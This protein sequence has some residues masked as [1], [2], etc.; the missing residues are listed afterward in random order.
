MSTLEHT[1]SVAFGKIPL[2]RRISELMQDRGDAFSIRA[3]AERL[4]ENRETFRQTL[5]G[6]RPISITLLENIAKGLK[7]DED[8][9]RQRDTFKKE[10]ELNSLLNAPERTKAMMLRAETL[11]K[12]LVDVAIG[13]TEP[14]MYWAHLG[15]AQFQLQLYDHAHESWVTSMRYAEKISDIFKDNTL[16]YHISSFLLISFT[17]RREYTN[18]LHTLE[19]V[20]NAFRDDPEKMGYVSY[21]R[22]KWHEHRR[23]MQKALEYSY[24]AL[25]YFKKTENHDQIGR[26]LIN[27]GHFEYQFEN[28]HVAK[29]ILSTAVEELAPF[30]FI[31]LYAI[32]DYVKTMIK[33]G[34]KTTANE[35]IEQYLPLY[36]D[37]PDMMGKLMILKSDA[38]H[39]P[40]FAEKIINDL[41]VGVEVRQ[42]ACKYLMEYSASS[43]DSESLMRY[44][45]KVKSLSLK[46]CKVFEEEG[47]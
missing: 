11:A 42:L 22:M 6:N 33:I 46:N 8:R 23:E 4:G 35:L 10:E 2:G 24:I 3:F 36:S 7:V 43:G 40:S 29:N 38:L 15:R 28:Y 32:K 21:T 31:R 5:L 20:E 13:W 41:R 37:Y 1:A 34:D 44:Y 19:V 47:F 30:D 18:I 12:E 27:V 9:L 45:N 39:D 14:C 26:A 16:L 25:D 17:V